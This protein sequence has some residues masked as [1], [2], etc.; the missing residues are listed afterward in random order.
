MV[1]T[2]FWVINTR[3]SAMKN[4][5]KSS[6]M[7]QIRDMVKNEGPSSLFKGITASIVLLI[8]PII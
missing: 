4:G 1:T 6:F 3:L 5:E 8:N 7:E 2:P